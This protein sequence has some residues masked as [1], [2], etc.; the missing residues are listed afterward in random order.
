MKIRF[1]FLTGIVWAA[2]QIENARGVLPPARPSLPNFDRRNAATVA[3]APDANAQRAEAVLKSRVPDL[4][5]LRDRS[6]GNPRLVP[7]ARGF[8]T[9]P[10]GP[11]EAV[12]TAPV[13]ASAKDPRA[14][15]KDFLDEHA[16]LFGHN[17]DVLTTATIRRDY[18]TPHNGL[19]TTIW[20]QTLDD[21]PV[22]EALLTGHVTR[23]G[24]LLSISSRFVPDAVRAADQGTPNRA[25]L[26]AS[27]TISAVEAVVRAAANLGTELNAG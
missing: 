21:L 8:L 1:L 3:P 12:A 10:G 17:S 19:H 18:V 11:G 27:P 5:I 16:A 24:E 2:C 4:N 22:F 25:G 13:S 15:I 9:G 20:E 14:I 26:I 7:A 23:Q 6:L